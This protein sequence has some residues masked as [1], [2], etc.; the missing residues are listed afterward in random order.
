MSEFTWTT[1][2]GSRIPVSKMTIPHLRNSIRMMQR[3]VAKLTAKR[4]TLM[5]FTG[6]ADP[7]GLDRIEDLAIRDMNSAKQQLEALEQELNRRGQEQ[8]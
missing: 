8:G 2:D 3:A 6:G 7:D 4:R 5:F 1:R